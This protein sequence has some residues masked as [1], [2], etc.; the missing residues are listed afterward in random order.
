MKPLLCNDILR[1]RAPEPY[2]REYFARWE[3]DTSLWDT[4]STSAPYSLN[5][6][7]EY[8]ATYNPD[9]F[10]TRQ[11]RLMVELTATGE[12]IGAVDIYDFDP[13]NRR[14]GVGFII[15]SA[16]RG[17]GYG[18][19]ALALVN[20]YCR[21]RLCVKQ[22]YAIVGTEN[23]SSR[24]TLENALYKRCGKLRRWICTGADRYSDAFIYQIVF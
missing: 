10:A 5:R 24:R 16:H 14:A 18:A 2:D 17:K 19:E 1:L 11:L 7:D 12:V 23:H 22:L 4:G 21:Q 15:D 20:Q 13:V 3:N 6:I 8:I 9:I